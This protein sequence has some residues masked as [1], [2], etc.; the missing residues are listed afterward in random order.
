MSLFCFNKIFLLSGIPILLVSTRGYTLLEPFL[1]QHGRKRKAVIPGD[2]NCLFSALSY[3]ITGTSEQQSQMRKEIAAFELSQK[4]VFQA[5]YGTE[6]DKTFD[7]HLKEINQDGAWGTDLETAAATLFKLPNV[8]M[9]RAGT[10]FW[11]LYSPSDRIEDVPRTSIPVLKDLEDQ[12][13]EIMFVNNH[14]F[15]AIEPIN[16][17]ERLPWPQRTDEGKITQ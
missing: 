13:I 9:D 3:Q 4:P 7:D 14:H 6:N 17:G 10:A 5:L 16:C 8:A 1:K 2:G 15:D 11:G 12:W